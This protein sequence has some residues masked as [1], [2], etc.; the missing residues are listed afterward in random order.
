MCIYT[1]THIHIFYAYKSVY[2]S[3][4]CYSPLMSSYNSIW[5]ITVFQRMV[6]EWKKKRGSCFKLITNSKIFFFKRITS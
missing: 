6:T 1:H 2:K 4:H 3:S 5:M